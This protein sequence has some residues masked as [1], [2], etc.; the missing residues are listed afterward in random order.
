MRLA[1]AGI[2]LIASATAVTGGG[3][4][5]RENEALA[6]AECV[7]IAIRDSVALL[8]PSQPG[9]HA[10]EVRRAEIRKELAAMEEKATEGV[11]KCLSEDQVYN[12]GWF[13]YLQDSTA[14]IECNVHPTA[15]LDSHRDEDDADSDLINGS[16][17]WAQFPP[18]L[19]RLEEHPF[20]AGQSAARA[21]FAEDIDQHNYAPA[22]RDMISGFGDEGDRFRGLVSRTKKVAEKRTVGNPPTDAEIQFAKLYREFQRFRDE[23]AFDKCGFGA[24]GHPRWL[25]GLQELVSDKPLGFALIARCE[26]VPGDLSML[27]MTWIGSRT[28]PKAASDKHYMKTMD[29]QIETC[30]S[31]LESAALD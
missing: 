15:A 16:V 21:Q 12:L 2:V 29:A 10:S 13:S 7:R 17:K 14:I 25:E 28:K 19:N 5:K 18:S 4:Q 6:A 3:K 20:Y 31:K 8:S 9:D 26:L 1:I 22:C 24:C 27:G 11:R 23:P 30:V